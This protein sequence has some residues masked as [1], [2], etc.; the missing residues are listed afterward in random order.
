MDAYNKYKTAAIAAPSTK[1]KLVFIFEEV[2]KLLYTAKK[3]IEVKDYT[4]KYKSLQKISNV[5]LTLRSGV[6]LEKDPE[7]GK[8]LD[9]F[10]REIIGKVNFINLAAKDTQEITDVIELV[11]TVRNA[12]KDSNN[13]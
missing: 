1:G 13:F 7:L 5:F 4:T 12:I 2:M 11:G 8:V 6:D 10:Y 3:A 9:G